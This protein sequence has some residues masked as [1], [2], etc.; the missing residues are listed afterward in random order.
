MDT[1]PPSDS[2]NSENSAL[3]FPC[4]FPIKAMGRAEAD[5]AALIIG[6]AARH[7]HDFD[8]AS[9]VTRVS[10][11][12]KYVSVTV[13]INATSRAQLDAIYRALYAS[14]QVLMAL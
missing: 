5:I 10:S 2:I 11:G 6:I 9:A 1:A 12:G 3:Q 8:P 14:D 13:M 7:A 4:R